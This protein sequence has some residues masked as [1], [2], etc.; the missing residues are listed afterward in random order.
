M[1][2]FARTAVRLPYTTAGLAGF[3]YVQVFGSTMEYLE[4]IAL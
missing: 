2:I 4:S 1:T 3:E